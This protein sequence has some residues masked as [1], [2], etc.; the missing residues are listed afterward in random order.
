M[1]APSA[2]VADINVGITSPQ[3]DIAV[4]V[5]SVEG[6]V[7]TKPVTPPPIISTVTDPVDIRVTVETTQ[8]LQVTV[9]PPDQPVVT[10]AAPE[11]P[12]VA[13]A[14]MGPQ[15]AKGDPGPTGLTGATGPQGVPGYVPVLE[16][17]TDPGAVH[18][19]TIWVETDA[20]IVSTSTKWTQM[21]QA[22]YDALAVKD[23][24]VLYVIVG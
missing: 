14:I 22:Q 16:Q 6:V 4:I 20:T 12:I 3:Q 8:D 7:V 10:V 24:N 2:K 1:T 21:T 23:P 17:D 5:E 18:E 11:I 15:G 13:S 19:G 9:Q